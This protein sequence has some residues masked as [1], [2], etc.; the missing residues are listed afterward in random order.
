VSVIRQQPTKS[1]NFASGGLSKDRKSSE[2]SAS[3][4]VK[5]DRQ[6]SDT[7]S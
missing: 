6:C 7:L 4:R 1:V 2:I 5:I 3:N